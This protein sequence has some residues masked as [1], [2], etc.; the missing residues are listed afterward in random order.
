MPPQLKKQQRK[1][2]R[3]LKKPPPLQKTQLL[4]HGLLQFKLQVTV[5]RIYS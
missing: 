5:W 1:K 4:K 2:L 3:L